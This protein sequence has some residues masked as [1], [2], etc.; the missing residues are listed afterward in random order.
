[1]PS[2][3]I[4]SKLLKIICKLLSKDIV[5]LRYCDNHTIDG[6]DVAMSAC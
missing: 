5:W 4:S 1:M 3:S 2:F 6:T